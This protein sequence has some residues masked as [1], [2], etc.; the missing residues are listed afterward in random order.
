MLTATVESTL[1]ADSL[2][3]DD[4]TCVPAPALTAQEP[5]DQSA[6]PTT[7]AAIGNPIFPT[8]AKVGTR[9][10]TVPDPTTRR[11]R[12]TYGH[13]IVAPRPAVDAQTGPVPTVSSD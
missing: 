11:G 12:R 13:K 2:P 4:V 1:R 9:D 7:A 8:T 10:T 5:E 6:R 3:V